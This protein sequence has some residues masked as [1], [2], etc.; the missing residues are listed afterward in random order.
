LATV[1][2]CFSACKEEQYQIQENDNIQDAKV[3]LNYLKGLEGN[4]QV[5]GGEEGVFGWE[6]DV[7]ARGN[8]IIERLKVGTPT[9]MTTVYNIDQGILKGSHFCQL[10]NQPNLI[11]VESDVEGD[12]HF[13]CDGNVGNTKSHDDLHMHGVH[14]QKEN[15]KLWIW[16]DMEENGKLAF[17]TRYQLTRID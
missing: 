12:L 3:A 17:E 14:F 13:L 16:M 15:D 10:Q 4:W 1:F 7:T 11:A 2:I 9:E 8:V 5:D 6:F